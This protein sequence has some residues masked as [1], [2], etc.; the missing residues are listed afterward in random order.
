MLS[1]LLDSVRRYARALSLLV[2]YSFSAFG[3]ALL[4]LQAFTPQLLSH[5]A[6]WQ[7]A[8]ILLALAATFTVLRIRTA[9]ESALT[10]VSRHGNPAG[11]HQNRH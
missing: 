4:C 2:T 3:I 11:P 9:D 5:T 6:I 1:P 8:W 7:L 10:S